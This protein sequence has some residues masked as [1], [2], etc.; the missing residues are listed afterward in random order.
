MPS[1][2]SDPVVSCSLLAG[3]AGAAAGTPG[4]AELVVPDGG[5]VARRRRR[6]GR[7]YAPTGPASIPRSRTARRRRP[8]SRRAPAP[9]HGYARPA[10]R[11]AAEAHGLRV[12]RRLPDPA[13]D[14]QVREL[15]D[16]AALR[17]PVRRRPEA[18]R[19]QRLGQ[20]PVSAR[21]ARRRHGR[22]LRRQHGDRRLEPLRGPEGPEPPDEADGPRHPDGRGR[23]RLRGDGPHDPRERTRGVRVRGR[24]APAAR[25]TARWR[26][27]RWA[28][29]PSPT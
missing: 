29:P 21:R 28:S 24:A 9:W 26:S 1:R 15:R 7:P 13:Q 4:V 11:A 27:P 22:S 25:P 2:V 8:P 12:Q 5:L 6:G 17:R 23:R 19:R 20:H 14:P 18:L 10:G 16:A 3:A